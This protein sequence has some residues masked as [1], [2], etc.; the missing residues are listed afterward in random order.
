VILTSHVDD[1]RQVEEQNAKIDALTE[2]LERLYRAG[3]G[4]G[5]S[6]ADEMEND[7]KQRRVP[8]PRTLNHVHHVVRRFR[9]WVLGVRAESVVVVW[10]VGSVCRTSS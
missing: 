4:K 9:Q 1:H 6:L 10:C 3:V 7:E 2:E 5:L 8:K